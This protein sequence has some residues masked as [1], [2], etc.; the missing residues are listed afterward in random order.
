MSDILHAVVEFIL[1]VINVIL[2]L[3][4]HLV[5]WVQY[6]GSYIYVVLFLIIFSETGLVILPFLPGDSLLFAAGALTVFD[7]GLDLTTL[8]IS[9]TIAAIL[10]DAVNYYLGQYFGPKVFES[11]SRF[12]KK[13]YLEQ[14]QEFYQRWGVFTIV[15]A[16]FAPIIRTFA[17]FIA[18]VGSM[19]YKK[20]LTYNVIGAVS[21]V[22]LFLLAGHFFGNL[23][24]VKT[25]FHIVIFA[26]IFVSVLP[27][28]IPWVKSKFRRKT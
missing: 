21:W 6:F 25:N 17:P 4:Q 1:H 28:L 11:D 12:F 15:A 24:V 19:H 10:G 5:S 2:H 13:K 7:G 22:C 3:D 26:V 20:F 27:M 8:L 9:L 16:R 23:P 18:G 14:T